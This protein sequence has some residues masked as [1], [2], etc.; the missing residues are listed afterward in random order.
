MGGPLLP[1][2][3][4]PGVFPAPS[5]GGGGEPPTQCLAPLSRP[6][7]ARLRHQFRELSAIA[8]IE[9]GLR[10]SGMNEW[11]V[12][13]SR[14]CKSRVYADFA[15]AGIRETEP[16]GSHELDVNGLH[17]LCSFFVYISNKILIL[18]VCISFDHSFIVLCQLSMTY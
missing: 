16:T 17:F 5:A 12:S 9:I 18:W 8:G 15:Y 6:P 10:S 1:P 2:R 13:Q 14:E 4:R 3:P 7:P 11:P